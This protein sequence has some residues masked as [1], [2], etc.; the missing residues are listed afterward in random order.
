[1][2]RTFRIGTRGSELALW[3]ADYV[4]EALEK[5]FPD[6]IFERI[7]I[8][9]EGDQNQQASLKQ[10]GGQG[11]F[12]KAIEMALLDKDIDIAIHSLKDLPSKMTG[13]LKLG[14]VPE[15][16]PVEDIL[17]TKQGLSF[18]QLPKYARIATGSIRRQSQILTRR[19]DLQISDL[20]GNIHTRIRKLFEL[21]LDAIIMAGAALK[22]LAINDIFYYT[23]DISEMIPAVGQGAIGIQIRIDDIT[24]GQIVSSLNHENTH[25]AVTAERSLLHTLDSGCQFPVGAHARIHNHTL[26]MVGFVGSEDGKTVLV[27]KLE[28]NPLKSRDAGKKLA[29]KLINRGAWTILNN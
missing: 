2:K 29:E 26:M 22:R 27:E 5:T 10:I 24:A 7:I 25:L 6:E 20:R 17:I 1:M 16:G 14:A 12:T 21:D 28:T 8:K 13:G 19:P 9:T 15:R 4:Q 18:N 11:V 3:Q 23:F